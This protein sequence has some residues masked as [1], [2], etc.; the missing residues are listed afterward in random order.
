MDNDNDRFGSFKL[1]GPSFSDLRGKQS[2]RVTFKLS[3]KAIDSLSIVAVQLGIKQKSLFDHLMDDFSVLRSVA[4]SFNQNRFSELHRVQ[5]TYVLSRNTLSLLEDACKKYNAPRD[6]VVEYSIK[7][8]E[9][10][11][12]IEKEKHAVRKLILS[13]YRDYLKKGEKLL[14]KYTALLDN[15]DPVLRQLENAFSASV[16]AYREINGYVEK[17]KVL[18]D[19]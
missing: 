8:L 11:I 19:Y 1:T 10:I 5:K 13:D 18:E 12:E 16:K 17:G 15:D 6:A 9:S 4:S 3:E 14:E 7:R 2:V